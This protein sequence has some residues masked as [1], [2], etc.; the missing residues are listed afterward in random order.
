MP[1]VKVDNSTTKAEQD[2]TPLNLTMI[3]NIEDALIDDME[4]GTSLQ[5]NFRA[6]H[7]TGQASKNLFDLPQGID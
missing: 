6:I 5:N 2:D 4:R 1:S 7:I 3:C